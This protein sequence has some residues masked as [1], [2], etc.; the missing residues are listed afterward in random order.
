MKPSAPCTLS[1]ISYGTSPDETNSLKPSA[2][3][4]WGSILNETTLLFPKTKSTLEKENISSA[5]HTI[6][7]CQQDGNKK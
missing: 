3:F 4:P 7:P 2:P 1:S 6:T 5:N